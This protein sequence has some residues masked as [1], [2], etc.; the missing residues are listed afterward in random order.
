MIE[1]A[2]SILSADLLRL[3]DQVLEVHRAGTR[4]GPSPIAWDSRSTSI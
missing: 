2:P 4:S 3:G 1:I